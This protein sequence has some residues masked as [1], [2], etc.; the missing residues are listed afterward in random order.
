MRRGALRR[1][2]GICPSL[3]THG[4]PKILQ[5]I[6]DSPRVRTKK[7]PLAP[8]PKSG[9]ERA[10]IGKQSRRAFVQ[11]ERD[12]RSEIRPDDRIIRCIVEQ[13]PVF[14]AVVPLLAPTGRAAVRQWLH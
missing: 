5:I 8:K 11:L 14:E 10:V 13:E 9:A 6:P 12:A 3:E 2:I 4:R 7:N 1:S